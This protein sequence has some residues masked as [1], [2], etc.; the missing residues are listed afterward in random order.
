MCVGFVRIA[1]GFNQMPAK[2][3]A[4][5]WIVIIIIIVASFT[6]TYTY[7]YSLNHTV[8]FT[9]FSKDMVMMG[10]CRFIPPDH[11]FLDQ[12]VIQSW[13][14]VEWTNNERTNERRGGVKEKQGH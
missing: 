7:I 9:R 8:A 11:Q 3:R 2:L 5:P 10:Y 4:V 14:G 6:S 12:T 13:S 1:L